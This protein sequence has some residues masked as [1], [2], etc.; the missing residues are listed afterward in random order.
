MTR[1]S[2][3][4]SW[5]GC[6]ARIRELEPTVR[7]WAH[8][9]PGPAWAWSGIPIG[10]KDIFNTAD[11]PT[12]HGSPLFA[13]YRPG[14]DARAVTALRRAG[15]AI[16]G[17]LHTSEFAVHEP[18]PT[19]NPLDL[20]RSPGTSSGG[21]AAAVAAGMVPMALCSQTAASTIRPASYCGVWGFKPSFGLIPRTG[22]L[23]TTDTL[24]TVG[25]MARSI[26]GIVLLFE[27]LRVRGPNHPLSKVRQDDRP[28]RRVAK[29]IG[30]KSDLQSKEATDGYVE[31]TSQNVVLPPEFHAAHD[32]HRIIYHKCLSYYLRDEYQ[33]R[34]DLFSA[35]LVAII[36]EGRTITV[37]Q[38]Q[39]ALADQ[40]RL[41]RQFDALMQDYDLLVCPSAAGEAPAWGEPDIADHSLIWTLCG[42]PA[43]SAPILKGPTGMPIG[44]QVVGR[45]FEDYKVLEFGRFLAGISN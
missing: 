37:E 23:H 42:A 10:V 8:Y 32:I 18:A 5:L 20:L 26:D 36:E 4:P 2:L 35:G 15:F 31:F 29:V 6:A 21:C 38:Y 22:M 9:E 7:A 16:V 43:L 12:E 25:M 24:D 3:P 28:A 39:A 17:K 13:G 41:A 45:R 11:W 27:T 1:P 19:R 34:P 30:P 33:R 44:V 14:N 40:I